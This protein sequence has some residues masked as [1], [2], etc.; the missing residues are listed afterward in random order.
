MQWRVWAIG[1]AC[2]VENY[3]RTIIKVGAVNNMVT[4]TWQV[5]TYIPGAGAGLGDRMRVD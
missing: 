4:Q 3:T 2:D 5:A 1:A